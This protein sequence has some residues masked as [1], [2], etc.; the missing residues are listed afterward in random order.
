MAVKTERDRET[1]A[2]ATLDSSRW[3]LT[4]RFVVIWL[5]SWIV[6]LRNVWL[7]CIV[8]NISTE[9]ITRQTEET[10]NNDVNSLCVFPDIRFRCFSCCYW[11]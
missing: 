5:L 1:I 9:I 3:K 6:M 8:A 2:V 7:S 10:I 4:I 11:Q